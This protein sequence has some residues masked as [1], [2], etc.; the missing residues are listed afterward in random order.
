MDGPEGLKK[1]FTNIK[2]LKKICYLGICLISLKA[3]LIGQNRNI[4]LENLIQLNVEEGF[5]VDSTFNSNAF[6]DLNVVDIEVEKSLHNEVKR[7]KGKGF[8]IYKY[9]DLVQ[10]P[11][12]VIAT[13]AHV[14]GNEI[15][16][17]V[18]TGTKV[19]FKILQNKSGIGKVDT[20][21]SGGPRTD[22]LQVIDIYNRNTVHKGPQDLFFLD[23]IDQEKEIVRKFVPEPWQLD[24]GTSIISIYGKF[25]FAWI[26]GSDISFEETLSFSLED[27]EASTR[28]L[29][30]GYSGSLFH[31]D[32]GA[33]GM[34]TK[35]EEFEEF[36]LISIFFI[37]T[38]L[39]DYKRTIL[40][41]LHRDFHH[42][43]IDID[44]IPEK[45][46]INREL[47]RGYFRVLKSGLKV[48]VTNIQK[49]S[50]KAYFS[51]YDYHSDR[52]KPI[53]KLELKIGEYE[54]FKFKDKT[55]RIFLRNIKW[56][57]YRSVASFTISYT[58]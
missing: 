19:W 35:D 20:L 15:F 41:D 46:V 49:R 17:E 8:I 44:Y 43:S 29:K 18:L 55:I 42:Y 4:D 37:K 48:L 36:H 50:D 54:E 2:K 14:V 57:V 52:P 23:I 5:V 13:P 56:S 53:K 10:R 16:E 21:Y 45:E 51:I 38:C 1:N 7:S 58:E 34:Y 28:Y 39:D 12:Y 40:K 6:L 47:Y 26:R 11:H 30:S 33:L 22:S 3:T 24:R 25:P 27:T 9:L 31:N 32:S